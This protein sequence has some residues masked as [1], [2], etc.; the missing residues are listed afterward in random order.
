[1]GIHLNL[2]VLLREMA[3]EHQLAGR[4]VMLGE[5][6]L[7]FD[8]TG[9]ASAAT[10]AETTTRSPAERFFRYLG[11]SDAASIDID[12]DGGEGADHLL[13]LNVDVTPQM[14]VE[15]FDLV[16]NGGTLEHV[17]HVPN[18]LA[19]VSRLLRPDGVV[20]H[21]LP[22]NN[23]VEHGFYQFSPTLM[24]DYYNAAGFTCLES[25]L[26][27]FLP[28]CPGCWTMR[29]AWPGQ[30]G[31][32]L[33]GTLDGAI[34]LHLFAARRGKHVEVLP[35]SQQRLYAG[36]ENETDLRDRPRWFEP[37]VLDGGERSEIAPLASFDLN[38]GRMKQEQGCAWIAPL[39]GLTAYADTP[40]LAA[41]ST[42]ILLADG[43][44]LGPS[45]A[46]HSRIRERGAG[47]YSPW[48]DALHFA[49]SDNSQ[50]GR[51]GRRYAMLLHGTEPS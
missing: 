39:T 22:C 46:P 51:N 32:G 42:L 45:H 41:R 12:I 4:V 8:P 15:Q 23:W 9:F 38:S 26:I 28:A 5:Q 49:A 50:P 43:I 16:L 19:H 30:L 47:R 27:R 2:A 3:A 13:D 20:V 44:P 36:P 21:V 1:V 40:G 29:C 34:Y 11:F 18:A 35:R 6:T 14:L 48:R 10:T 17:F 37:F 31:Q 7:D 24:F 25:M 33:A